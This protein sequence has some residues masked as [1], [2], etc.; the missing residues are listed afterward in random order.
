MRSRKIRQREER[1][2]ERDGLTLPNRQEDEKIG[3]NRKTDREKYV[4]KRKTRTQT[5]K[6]Q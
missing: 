5:K 6:I 1:R 4:Q 3:M 2:K